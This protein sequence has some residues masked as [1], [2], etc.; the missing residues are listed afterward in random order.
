MEFT[1]GLIMCVYLNRLFS[2]LVPGVPGNPST[3]T[4]TGGKSRELLVCLCEHV[5][6]FV[7]VLE[8]CRLYHLLERC[9]MYVHYTNKT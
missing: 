3:L 1:V 8:F 2:G 7:M 4:T 5:V 9:K 6:F